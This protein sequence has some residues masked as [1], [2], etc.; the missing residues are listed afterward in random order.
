[1]SGTEARKTLAL[2]LWS[3]LLAGCGGGQQADLPPGWQKIAPPEDVNALALQGENLWAGGRDGLFLLHRS[4]GELLDLPAAIPEV[5]YVRDLLVD[6]AGVLYVAHAKGL[7][8]FD[9]RQW[10]NLSAQLQL[11]PGPATALH[12]DADGDLWVGG[13]TGVCRIQRV[14]DEQVECIDRNDGLGLDSV[15]AILEDDAGRL[16]FASASQTSGGL[17]MYDGKKWRHF[18]EQGSL[19]HNRVTDLLL[20]D[21]GRLLAATGFAESGGVWIYADG[22]VSVLLPEDGLAGAVVR[23]LY[24]DRQGRMYIGS[25]FNGLAVIEGKKRQILRPRD[26]LAGFEVKKVL[27]DD[28]GVLWL[29]T[30]KGLNRVRSAKDLWD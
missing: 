11:P 14:Q 22:E 15:D 7:G 18:H 21:R 12:E 29:A 27:Q 16:W 6:R 24:Q 19:P 30:N 17:S 13:E 4:A 5:V 23:S 20:D 26:G 9:G 28:Q 2:L 8:S 25:E 3:M 10:R 1:M